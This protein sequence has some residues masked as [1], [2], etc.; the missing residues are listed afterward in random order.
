MSTQRR[1]LFV[2]SSAEKT[3]RG[4]PTGYWLSEAAH[5]YHILAPKFNIDFASPKKT[6]LVDANSVTAAN[7]ENDTRSISFLT[8]PVVKTKAMSALSLKE[9]NAENYEAIFYVGGHAPVID[10]SSDPDNAK[11]VEAFWEQG[12]YVAAVCHGPAALVGARRNGKSIFAG[13]KATGFSNSEENA[14]QGAED[15]PFLLES[16]IE[17]LEGKFEKAGDFESHVVVDG[18]LLTGQNPKSADPLANKLLEV[19]A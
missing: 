6:F 3:L 15:V 1:I 7:E 16:K 8:D 10:L 13:K 17:E 14:F 19:L 2:F 5:P 11:L 12:K 4:K 9:V 18:K